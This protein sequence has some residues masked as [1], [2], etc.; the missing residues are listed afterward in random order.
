MRRGGRSTLLGESSSTR[1]GTVTL[2]KPPKATGSTADVIG[3][4]VGLVVL[5]VLFAVVVWVAATNSQADAVERSDPFVNAP[6][7]HLAAGPSTVHVRTFGPAGGDATVVV[8]DDVQVGSLS[9]VLVG[10]ELAALDERV[11][12]PD[13]LGYGLSGR[14]SEPGRYYTTAGQAETLAEVLD[15]LEVDGARVAGF[16]W[17]GAVAAELAVIRPD[18]VSSVVMIDTLDLPHP[19]GSW[20]TLESLPFGVG[21]AMAYTFEGGAQSARER[22]FGSCEEG[23]WCDAQPLDT[24]YRRMVEVP[25][26]SEAIH[27]RSASGSASVASDRIAEIEVP[28]T[29]AWSQG[30]PERSDDAAEALAGRFPDGRMVRLPEVT[31]PVEL[32]APAAAAEAIAAG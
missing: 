25:G 12:A 7:T 26:T 24:E 28:V 5:L 21:R 20:D 8:H 13:L 30:D 32:A 18:L 10:E 22:F 6:G 4:M 14:P 19:P 3:R 2:R 31:G 9:V 29:V 16:G 11:V 15:E 17:G 1:E 27:A 23:G